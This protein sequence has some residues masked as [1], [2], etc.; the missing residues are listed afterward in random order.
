MSQIPSRM[1]LPKILI[2]KKSV[3]ALGGQEVSK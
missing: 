1:E 3:G 2:M